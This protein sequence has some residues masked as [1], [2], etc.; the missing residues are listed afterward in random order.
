MKIPKYIEKLAFIVESLKNDILREFQ[1]SWTE[2]LVLSL[3]NE[4][5]KN[6]HQASPQEIVCKSGKNRGWIYRA[7]RKLKEKG[8]INLSEGKSFE[9]G[10]LFMRLYGKVILKRI[11]SIL[12]QRVQAIKEEDLVV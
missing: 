1:L 9:P 6:D 2:Y 10:R 11:N 3:V 8:Y 12:A 5:E 7:I 4:F